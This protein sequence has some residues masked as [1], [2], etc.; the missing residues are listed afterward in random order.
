MVAITVDI[1][2]FKLLKEQEKESFFT[3]ITM[4]Y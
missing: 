4:R 2:K 1:Y 3:P